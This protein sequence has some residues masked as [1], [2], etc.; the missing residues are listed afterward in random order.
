MFRNVPQIAELSGPQPDNSAIAGS[1][2]NLYRFVSDP[3]YY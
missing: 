3:G 1:V 2:T